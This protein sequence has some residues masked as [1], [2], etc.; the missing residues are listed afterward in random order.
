MIN[1]QLINKTLFFIVLGL[2]FS[3]CRNDI[4][5]ELYAKY[6]DQIT[7]R[8]LKTEFYLIHFKDKGDQ[9]ISDAENYFSPEAKLKRSLHNIEYNSLDLPVSK[10]YLRR[11]KET[12]DVDIELTTKWFNAAVIATDKV[13]KVEDLAGLDFIER[14]ETFGENKDLSVYE[15][16]VNSIN[17]LNTLMAPLSNNAPVIENFENLNYGHNEDFL[18]FH[19]NSLLSKGFFG[20]GISIA[21]LADGFNFADHSG[22]SGALDAVQKSALAHIAHENRFIDTYHIP[23]KI[24]EVDAVANDG[25]KDLEYAAA[26]VEDQYIGAAPRA[27][28][29]LYVP[30]STLHEEQ[31]DELLWVKTLERADSVG[32]HIISSKHTYGG[33]FDDPNAN[34]Q[35]EELDGKVAFSSRAVD[36]AFEKDMLVVNLLTGSTWGEPTLIAPNDAENI[37]STYGGSFS[38]WTNNYRM[39]T[40]VTTTAD[41]RTKPDAFGLDLYV[42]DIRGDANY[43]SRTAGILLASNIACLWS[44]TP[45][46][47]AK[48]IRQILI[49]SQLEN[50]TLSEEANFQPLPNI[51]PSDNS[52]YFNINRAYELSR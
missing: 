4:D 48:E 25:I 28:Y 43:Y 52:L 11:I 17:R 15:N 12:V 21:I 16:N 19:N 20:Q 47:S 3:N 40:S 33:N 42:K 9:Q 23:K 27:N 34:Y 30:E 41:G 38:S 44:S 36:I 26:I 50:G 2:L 22:A 8:T 46:K 7:P 24:N 45:E 49:D 1:K 13:F 5:Q 10:E 32:I 39:N 18:T 31:I 51:N 6:D 35:P 29:A 37:I 14:I